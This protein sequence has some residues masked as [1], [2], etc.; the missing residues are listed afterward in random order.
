MSRT[1]VC[2]LHRLN[3]GQAVWINVEWS[4]GLIFKN[5][6]IEI[7]KRV[8]F[9]KLYKHFILG[10]QHVLEK[11]NQNPKFIESTCSYLILLSTNLSFNVAT[12]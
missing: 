3:T 9:R 5:N 8:Y 6:L 10:L 12:F 1:F 4:T 7:Y 11:L 2:C